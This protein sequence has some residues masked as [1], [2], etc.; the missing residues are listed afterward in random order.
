MSEAFKS[1][2]L[3]AR[4]SSRGR[5]AEAAGWPGQNPI[6]ASSY[7]ALDEF[8]D[9]RQF[10]M[11]LGRGLAVLHCFTP[12]DSELSNAE[13]AART[14]MAKATI[15]RFTYTLVRMGYLR[16]NRANGKY[17]LGSAVLSIGYPLLSSLNIRQIARPLMKQLADHIKGSV[18]LG[19]RDRLNVVYIE[20]SQGPAHLPN[21]ADVGLSFPIARTA[22]GR[23]LIAA[24]TPEERAALLNQLRVKV[25]DQWAEYHTTIEAELRNFPA[26]GYCTSFGDWQPQICAVA[27]PMR[28]MPDGEILV[29]NCSIPTYLLGDDQ[30]SRD[31]GPRLISMVRTIEGMLGLR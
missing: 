5:Q 9:D 26:R 3:R 14:G 11:T 10:A 1:G 23:A 29:F 7:V 22:M 12:R 27:V 21:P 18:A 28:A 6:L 30:L 24:Y 25:P 4:S 17:Q 19:M 8:E 20:T 15:S 13:L 2:K 16:A 31:I